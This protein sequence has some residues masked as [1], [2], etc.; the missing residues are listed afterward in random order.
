MTEP[1]ADRAREIRTEVDRI[2]GLDYDGFTRSVV[3]PQGQFDAFL[4]GEPKERR[5]ILVALLSLSVYER[6]QQLANQRSSAA[7]AEAE[8]IKRQLETDFAS[9]TQEALE[10]KK[11]ELEAA[12]GSARQAEA[13]LASLAE[14]RENRPAGPLIPQRTRPAWPRTTPT[15]LAASTKRKPPSM[16]PG[17]R[18]RRSTQE[19]EKLQAQK[20][21]HGFDEARH[22]TLVAAKPL[23]DQLV[24]LQQGHTRATK[25]VADKRRDLEEARNA[26]ALVRRRPSRTSRKPKPRPGQGRAPRE[27]RRRRPTASTPPSPSARASSPATP[28]PSARRR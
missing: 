15:R 26:V 13:A 3:L 17:R 22:T 25:A 12:E 6:M 11:A 16:G 10:Q 8:F 7:K 4:K 23:A 20:D 2:L 19:L 5:K 18:R 27:P 28:A 21:A 14:A 24:G 9:A 1:I